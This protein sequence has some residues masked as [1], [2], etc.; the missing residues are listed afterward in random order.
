MGL[1][2]T[3]LQRAPWRHCQSPSR[4]VACYVE[5]SRRTMRL[6]SRMWTHPLVERSR[7]CGRNKTQDGHSR[8]KGRSHRRCNTLLQGNLVK[9][10]LWSGGI[11]ASATVELSGCSGRNIRNWH[12]TNGG[13]SRHHYPL[14]GL[15][16]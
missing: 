11:D 4:K 3:P 7:H 14:G 13:L 6:P 16:E 12:G 10:E 9:V 15:R 1:S 2:T 8:R 5:I